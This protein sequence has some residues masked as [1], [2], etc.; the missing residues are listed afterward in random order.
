MKMKIFSSFWDPACGIAPA[1]K[2]IE[3]IHDASI[4]YR[5]ILLSYLQKPRNMNDLKVLKSPFWVAQKRQ[6]LITNINPNAAARKEEA[7][8]RDSL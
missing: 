6:S 8:A 3:K 7:A 1:Y 2:S 5:R 4:H